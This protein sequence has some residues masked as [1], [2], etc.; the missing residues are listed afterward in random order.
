MVAVSRSGRTV[1]ATGTVRPRRIE[2][3]FAERVLVDDFSDG[4]ADDSAAINA[5]IDR[6][7]ALR[8]QGTRANV[9]L[10]ARTYN[11]ATPHAQMLWPVGIIGEGHAASVIKIDD[12]LSGDVF[13]W[14]DV[15]YET[16]LQNNFAGIETHKSS[17]ILRGFS[18]VGTREAASQQNA[19]MFYDRTD[20]ALIEDVE[21]WFLKGRALMF[22]KLDNRIQG[23]CRESR[24]VGFGAYACGDAGVPVVEFSSYG[25]G[26]STNSNEVFGLSAWAC[27]GPGL[28]LRNGNTV[29]PLTYM[30][31][32]G[33]RIE[34][35]VNTQTD[36]LVVIGDDALEGGVSH[37]NFYGLKLI[38]ADSGTYS[39]TIK[40]PDAAAGA[41]HA[42]MGFNGVV[43]G[44]GSGGGINI[45]AGRELRFDI[46]DLNIAETELTVGPASQGIGDI[47]IQG[48][49][50]E[51][52]WTT[53]I[54]GT[55]ASLVTKPTLGAFS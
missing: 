6:C 30:D 52:G 39:L 3:R 42:V 20:G 10:L 18:V 32:F 44:P 49:G 5:A 53:D 14:S 26:D 15:W 29:K 19:F 36:D 51:V 9:H 21:V 24:I 1:L 28:V 41:R 43:I 12:G 33:T 38:G 31:F 54:D 17:P 23:Y 7:I 2:D 8:M 25:A 34:G 16:S 40:A 47:V 4:S 35:G 55:S 45:Q 27:Y 50:L 48:H 46:T 22:G 11:Y 37:V 13:S